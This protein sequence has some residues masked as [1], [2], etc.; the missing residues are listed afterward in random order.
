MITFEKEY[1]NI[2]NEQNNRS[3]ISQGVISNIFNIFKNAVPSTEQILGNSKQQAITN[4]NSMIE[5]VTNKVSTLK[6]PIER[7]NEKGKKLQKGIRQPYEAAAK[8]ENVD[9]AIK[10]NADKSSK[11]VKG[12]IVQEL[13][14]KAKQQGL[15]IKNVKVVSQSLNSPQFIK[16]QDQINKFYNKKLSNHIKQLILQNVKKGITPNMWFDSNAKP[17]DQKPII[18][19]DIT[20]NFS[21]D[22]D[23][24]LICE[25]IP[26]QIY[27]KYIISEATAQKIQVVSNQQAAKQQS[28][29]KYKSSSST[30]KK[31]RTPAQI[32]AFKKAQEALK[33]KRE[34]VKKDAALGAQNQKAQIKVKQDGGDIMASS[35]TGSVTIQKA[36]T[37][38]NKNGTGFWEGIDLFVQ[39]IGLIILAI[40]TFVI[41][42]LWFIIKCFI[43][44]G[45]SIAK[46][47]TKKG[48]GG[49]LPSWTECQKQAKDLLHADSV[50]A[51]RI[52]GYF[53]LILVGGALLALKYI[54]GKSSDQNENNSNES[55]IMDLSPISDFEV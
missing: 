51:K 7:I 28:T 1:L 15:K 21:L 43:Q 25:Q 19:E 39:R 31:E 52:A 55:Q 29:K 26:T 22:N 41:G 36:G 12:V 42:L 13:A 2:I 34:A 47:I 40:I 32:A 18:F 24:Y 37:I 38:I 45:K 44:F 33:A 11:W 27:K 4:I 50:L 14:N 23:G 17:E 53:A 30:T 35:D 5:K 10:Q 54:P 46:F 20:Y 8:G 49:V 48:N 6:D 16:K 9:E 3:I